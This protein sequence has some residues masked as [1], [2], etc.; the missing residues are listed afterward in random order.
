MSSTTVAN[1]DDIRVREFLLKPLGH[2]V[3]ELMEKIFVSLNVHD[4]QQDSL[5]V[6][7]KYD[8]T[9]IRVVAWTSVLVSVVRRRGP[10]P[11]K[12]KE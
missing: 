10:K 4:S 3:R 5:N 11:Q 6:F 8:R 12:N 2:A 1:D 9:A 7:R